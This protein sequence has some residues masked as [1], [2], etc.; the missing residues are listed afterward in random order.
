[1]FDGG[2]SWP[3]LTLRRDAVEANI[4][5]FAAY[6]TQAGVRH[7]PH[8]K[9]TMAPTIVAAQ[10]AAGAWGMTVATAH[11]AYALRELGVPRVLLANELLDGPALRW[12]AEQARLGWRFLCYVDSP[13]G[14]Q[15]IVRAGVGPEFEV[16]VEVGYPGGRTGCRT[17]EQAATVAAAAAEAGVT[18]A[19][20]AGYE[21]GLPDAAAV[22]GYLATLR[23]AAGAVGVALISAGGSTYPDVV[24]EELA[25]R[26]Y[27]VVLRSGAYVTHDDGLYAARTPFGRRIGAPLVPAL[28]LWAQVL[29][30]PEAGLAIAGMGK[31][32]VGHDEGLP[33]PLAVR[34]VDGVHRPARGLAVTALNDQHAYVDV[35]DDPLVP[36]ELVCFG[37]SHPCTTMDRW[38]V[39]PLVDDDH[40]VVELVRTR[41]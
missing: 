31:R 21:G 20:V 24:V 13:A 26:G 34:G 25:G 35:R 3:V 9:T 28:R 27:E 22:R 12:A 4:A 16:L 17:V 29:S 5:A 14:V 23:E 15:A 36:G 33:V 11:Q 2:Y 37:V 6:C 8:A 32:D 18:V 38:R 19:G 30:A 41:F 1:L 7:A 10:L 40:R 39:I